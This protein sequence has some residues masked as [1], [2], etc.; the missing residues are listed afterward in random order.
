MDFQRMDNPLEL[1][2][3][4]SLSVVLCELKEA[5]LETLAL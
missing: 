1:L 3:K 4:L 5:C 2:D